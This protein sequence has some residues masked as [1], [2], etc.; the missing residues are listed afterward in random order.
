MHNKNEDSDV[1]P[2]DHYASMA[3]EVPE[4]TEDDVEQNPYQRPTD[5]DTLKYID[6]QNTKGFLE[7]NF[8]SFTKGGMRSS[9]FTM[10]SGTVG[11]GLLSLP[12][13]IAN[14]GLGLGLAAIL[15]FALLTL[16]MYHILN[17]LILESG[18]KSYANVVSFYLGKPFGRFVTQFL[19]FVMCASGMLFASVT[20]QFTSALLNNLGVVTFVLDPQTKKIDQYD[21]LTVRWRYICCA[22]YSVLIIPV[23]YQRSLAKLRFFTMIIVGVVIYTILVSVVQAPLYFSAYKND[24]NYKV[25]WLLADFNTS[26]FKGFGTLMLSFNCQ[27]LFFY[28]R[29]E[30]M[31]K[32]EKRVTKL[33]SI[34]VSIL[35]LVFVSM[36]SAAYVSL[37]KN[38]Q[39][40]LFT[41]RRKVTEDSGDYFMLAAQMLFLVACFFK[42][43]LVLFPAREQMYIFYGFSRKG[44]THLTLTVAICLVVFAVPCFYPDITNFIGLLGGVTIGSAGYS[45]PV[46]VKLASLRKQP[47]GA[48]QLFYGAIFITIVSIQVL[49]TTFSIRD[50]IKAASGKK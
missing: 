42:I 39:P 14:F 40:D 47:F 11:P 30:L 29:G 10:F 25:D 44:S 45:I 6:D 34:L 7:R 2:E 4:S 20:W 49:S 17:G 15:A 46:L 13:V 8:T 31:H 18:K 41:L 5:M 35:I 28:V 24:P 3:G 21:P 23:V 12:K 50:S 38:M 9:L 26:W 32:S 27:V 19:I 22:A 36:C 48:S 1:V 43:A 37:G 33:V 16:L